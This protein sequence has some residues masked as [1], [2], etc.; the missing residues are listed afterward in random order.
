[1]HGPYV[2]TSSLAMHWPYIEL[3]GR[4]RGA[5]KKLYSMTSHQCTV[6]PDKWAYLLLEE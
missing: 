6:L 2:E 4:N 3:T 1:M 5:K